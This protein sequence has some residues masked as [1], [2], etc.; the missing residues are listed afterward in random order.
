MPDPPN[1]PSVS[2]EPHFRGVLGGKNPC[3]KCGYDRSGTGET[4]C[5]EC[6]AGYFKT[7]ELDPDRVLHS[8]WDEPAFSPELMSTTAAPQARESYATWLA[9]RAAGMSDSQSWIYVLLLAMAA[10]PFGLLGAMFGELF[11]GGGGEIGG[12]VFF[13]PM[14][15]ELTKVAVLTVMI[16]RRPYIFKRARQVMLCALAGG[17]AFAVL[18]NVLYLK[19]YV[20]D[21]SEALIYWRWTVCVALHSGCSMIAGLGLVRVWRRTM[22]HKTRPNLAQGT[23]LMVTAIVLHGVYNAAALGMHWM[24]GGF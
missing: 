11:E 5:P 2:Q 6:G 23:P 7:G 17:V 22:A 10:G 8:V 21:P 19:V 14:F 4:N 20:P 18:E 15:E 1:D 3:W 12:L 16:E 9:S 24:G 13:G